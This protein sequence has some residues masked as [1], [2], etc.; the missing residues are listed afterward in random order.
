MD[1]DR[2]RKIGLAA[3]VLLAP[4]GFILGAGLAAQY[5]RRRQQE[6][7]ARDAAAAEADPTV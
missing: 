7:R 3:V 2:Y 6:R 4:G 1:Q 5:L